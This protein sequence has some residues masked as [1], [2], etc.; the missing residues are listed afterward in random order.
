MSW[1]IK[2][3]DA[4]RDKVRLIKQ[5]AKK[6]MENDLDPHIDATFQEAWWEYQ[7]GFLD[8]AIQ[9]LK[10]LMEREGIQEDTTEA[11]QFHRAAK[12]HKTM[13]W[14]VK[15]ASNIEF[16]VHAEA[17]VTVGIADI[18]K[19]PEI[20]RLRAS[21]DP[22]DRKVAKAQ[23]VAPQMLREIVADKLRG[24]NEYASSQ[25]IIILNTGSPEP[26]DGN[27]DWAEYFNRIDKTKPG[28]KK[29]EIAAPKEGINEQPEAV[30]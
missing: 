23:E 12:E 5:L 3:D 19:R 28:T 8:E 15:A 22:V 20:E 16:T 7:G 10:Q 9:T 14:T 17:K 21:T 13:G 26:E 24:I 1:T 18:E 25:G 6:L 2:A 4:S 11:M 30:V 27:I 29:P